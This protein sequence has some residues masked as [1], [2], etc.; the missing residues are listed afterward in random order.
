MLQR[1][2]RLQVAA[3]CYRGTGTATQVLLITSRGT[4]RWVIPKGWPMVGKSAVEAAVT[5]AWEEAGVRAARAI[6]R[7]LGTFLYDKVKA[8][9]LPVGVETLVYAVQVDTLEDDFPEVS[10]RTR[11]WVAPTE[12]AGMVKE[13]GLQRILLD[14]AESAGG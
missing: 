12:A 3:L 9:G 8:S 14:F 10:Q 6:D 5:E 13:S 11:R 2:R 4:G 1:P 7:P